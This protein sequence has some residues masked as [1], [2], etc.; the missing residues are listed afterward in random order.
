M[1]KI[2]IIGNSGS[3]KSTLAK[4]L[5]Q[6]YSLVHLDL[7]TLA[8]MPEQPGVRVPLEESISKLSAFMSKQRNWVIEGCYASLVRVALGHCTKLFFLNPGINTCINN[9]LSR[10]WEPHK[11]ESLEAQNH[12]L[13]MLINWVKTYATRD[14]EYSLKIHRQL[15]EDFSGEKIELLSNESLSEEMLN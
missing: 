4:T 15:F 1:N 5:A 3:G 14:D 11:Y 13:E 7:D 6:K 2:V 10:P 12:N 9:C 8:W